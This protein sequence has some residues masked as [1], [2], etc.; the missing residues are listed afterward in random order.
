VVVD[1]LWPEAGFEP[2][3]FDDCIDRLG[4]AQ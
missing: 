3:E 2:D 1:Q 4:Q